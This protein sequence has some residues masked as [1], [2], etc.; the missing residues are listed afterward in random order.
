MSFLEASSYCDFC[1]LEKEVKKGILTRRSEKNDFRIISDVKDT[2]NIDLLIIADSIEQDDSIRKLQL[3]LKK[4]DIYNYAIVPA[5]SCRCKDYAVPSP[6]YSTY[7]YCKSLDI[8]KFNPKAILV[9]NR[10]LFYFTKNA[11]ISSWRYFNEFLFN[12]TWFL[13][14]YDKNNNS[15]KT[16]T[17][18]VGIFSDIVKLNTF[19]YLHFKEQLNNIKQYLSEYIEP[20]KFIE[21]VIK[22]VTNFKSFCEEHI[23]EKYIAI[24]TE[25]NSLNVFIDDF[26]I[27][28]ITMSFD[29]VTGYYIPFDIIDKQ[30]LKDFLS[31]KFLI[32]ANGKYDSKALERLGIS[33]IQVNE[34][35]NILFHLMNTERESN[36]IKVL[37]WLIGFGNYDKKLKEYVKKHKIKS[38]LDIPE[39]LLSEYAVLDVIVTFRLW[40]YA[41]QYLIP[42]Q[43]DVYKLYRDYVIP[44]IPVL[45]DMETEGILVDKEYIEKYHH[46]LVE[47]KKIIEQEIYEIAGEVFNIAS[48]DDLG[49]ILEKL[50]L[51]DYGRTKKGLYRTGEEILQL[52]KNGKYKIAEKLLDYRA[53]SKLDNTFVG[54]EQLEDDKKDDDDFLN[55]V[56]SISEENSSEGLY[57]YIMSDGRIHGSIMPAMT[58]SIRSLSLN[59]NLQN[60]P[61]QG[62][63][64]KL[65]RKVF[66]PPEDYLF[67]EADYSGFQLRIAGLYSDDPVMKDI[68]INLSG[69]MHSVTA[70]NVFH[71][72]MTLEEFLK[73]K[74][75][76]P[77]KTSRFKSKGVNFGF[78]FGKLAYSFK[79]NI[80]LE[81][82]KEEIDEYIEI[83][84]LEI[85]LDQ[86][87]NQDR[88]LTVAE[89]IRNKFFETY[90][91]LLPWMNSFQDFAK[92]NGYIES[93]FFKGAK[94][95][96]PDLLKIGKDL[97]KEKQKYYNNLL[98]IAIN[99]T[100]QSFEALIVY[101]ALR[102]I[103]DGIKNNNLKSRLIA[104]VH[105]SIVLY[106]HTSEIEQMYYI[107]KN[108][109][110]TYE[111]DIPIIIEQEYGRVWGFGEEVNDKNL[112]EFISGISE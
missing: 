81:W 76:E 100:V 54:S 104:T 43:P 109:M 22:S 103:W 48:N 35:I 14:E 8:K 83:N 26:K 15:D 33:G 52:W 18:P 10:A 66:I 3:I 25:T 38:Y 28:C 91:N 17:Y 23:N 27:G 59:P 30:L 79:K 37:A 88:L 9:F 82:S 53:V 105:D 95:H 96:L 110:E 77:Y 56:S 60:F 16:R 97:G 6:A 61:K 74:G 51:P 49:R 85:V 102:K 99:S 112:K 98:N 67:C 40:Q 39:N 106:I 57:K 7:A 89:D 69:D 36:S 31:D 55:N 21:P 72:N 80:E 93:P 92:Q 101:K 46:E 45:Q 20:I 11:D 64:G 65:F 34:D 90:T 47:R 108:S 94:R 42:K 73:V 12:Q 1:P 24:D 78:I 63:E 68:F 75:K 19:E 5:I 86:H 50:G 62:S 111:Y 71:R 41:K 2:K 32:W 58:S 84:K 107:I 87:G 70:V 4:Q 13:N 44:V 29:G